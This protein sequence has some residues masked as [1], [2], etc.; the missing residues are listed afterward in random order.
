MFFVGLLSAEARVLA[1]EREGDIGRR[2]KSTVDIV[3]QDRE[4][5]G[6]ARCEGGPLERFSVDGKGETLYIGGGDV[7]TEGQSSAGET[8]MDSEGDTT[9][10]MSTVGELGPDV[11]AAML[12]LEPQGSA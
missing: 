4:G 10:P 9:G 6:G 12:S 2:L 1:M 5:V 11:D 8:M 3:D 7:G